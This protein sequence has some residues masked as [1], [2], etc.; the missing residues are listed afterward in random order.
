MSSPQSPGWRVDHSIETVTHNHYQ[1]AEQS[2]GWLGL[3]TVGVAVAAVA[4]AAAFRYR[5]K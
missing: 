3:A 1:E 5:M 2:L 4:A